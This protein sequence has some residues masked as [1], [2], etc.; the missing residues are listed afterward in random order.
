[1]E[2]KRYKVNNTLLKK[3]VKYFWVI[4]SRQDLFVNHNLLPVGNIDIILNFS[5]PIKYV[6]DDGKEIVPN[7]FHLNGI[8]NNK[9]NIQQSGKLNIIGISFFSMGLYPL[10]KIPLSEF[11]NQ[12][13]ELDIINQRFT[14]ELQNKLISDMSILNKLDI[15][16]KILV[17]FINSELLPDP[18]IFEVVNNL[19]TNTDHIMVEQFCNKYGLHKRK[20]ERV[21][22]KYVGV[23]P[24]SFQ[25]LSRFQ[26]VLNQII[27][28]DYTNLTT[29][30]YDYDYYD[31][32]HFTK[33]FKSFTGFSP[34]QF[35]NK[36][37]S[38]KELIN[39]T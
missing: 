4:N 18:Y 35:I 32:T 37:T 34:S 39:C 17:Q 20:L 31:Q 8:R 30:A 21:F 24:K 28:G 22:T 23:S 12:T 33:E 25:K 2:F 9:Y 7:E 11:T 5:S 16:E 13:I 14:S 6:L 19:Y 15:I 26:R 10:L 38:V 1:M 29:L 3:L 36:R 27:H